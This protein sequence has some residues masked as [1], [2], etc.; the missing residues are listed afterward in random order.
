MSSRVIDIS[1]Y[2]NSSTAYLKIYASHGVRSMMVK[3]TEGTNYLNPKAGAQVGNGFKVFD[4]V[5][6]YHYFLGNGLVEAKYFLAHVR[7]LG[8]DKSTVLGIDVEDP[9]LTYY[10]TPQVNVFLKALKDAGYKRVVT[11]GSGSWFNTGRISRSQL[12]DKHIWVAAY[13]VS[14]PGV[15]N[16]NAWQYTDNFYGV[17]ASYDFDGTLK[18]TNK[19]S[20]PDKPEYYLTPGL[21][22]VTS[23][24][25]IN[26]YLDTK[27]KQKRRV[28]FEKGSRIYAK[29]I[30]Y[31]EIYRLKTAVG[32]ITANKDYI[33]FLMKAGD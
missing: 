15:A 2:Q 14:Q 30:K 29:P 10:T 11:Y 12:L 19:A 16:A 31:G 27:F 7:A 21:Y 26:V 18:G 17:D 8:L 4:T 22:E 32:Y 5:G 13:G 6:V 24:K 20:K 1:S 28:R 3:L 23:I 9:S 25:G 33:K